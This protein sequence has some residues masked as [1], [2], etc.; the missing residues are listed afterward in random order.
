LIHADPILLRK[1][2]DF[3]LDGTRQPQRI[4]ALPFSCPDP[5]KRFG[6]AQYPY[7]EPR[8]RRAEIPAIECHDRFSAPIDGRFENEFIGWIAQLWPPQEM[9]FYWLSHRKHRVYEN[10][11]LIDTQPRNKAMFGE[12]VVSY[13]SAK[14][15]VASI[16]SADWR[17]AISKA[18][19]APRAHLT[20]P[21]ISLTY[22]ISQRGESKD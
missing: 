9:R 21:V 3:R 14:A 2:F 19:E 15:T 1:S 7:T 5:T 8:G 11:H 10:V 17:A 20:S 16:V 4:G 22:L 18:A 12:Q 6:G 13:S